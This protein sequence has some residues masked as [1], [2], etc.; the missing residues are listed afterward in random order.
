MPLLRCVDPGSNAQ[1]KEFEWPLS[2]AQKWSNVPQC[3]SFSVLDNLSNISDGKTSCY[4]VLYGDA[5]RLCS[6][7]TCEHMM[8]R[9]FGAGAFEIV[10]RG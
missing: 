9:V 10:G 6:C 1:G 8:L 5:E 4:V 2:V 3:R 7:Y